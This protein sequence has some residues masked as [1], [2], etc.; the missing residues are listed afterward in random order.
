MAQD[1]VDAA[2]LEE[3]EPGSARGL[4]HRD[5]STRSFADS[6]GLTIG[7]SP[8]ITSKGAQFTTKVPYMSKL[9][10]IASSAVRAADKVKA[11]LIIVYT[12]TGAAGSD[13]AF[14]DMTVTVRLLQAWS[15]LGLVS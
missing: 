15:S 1:A 7:L 10:S 6:E 4:L 12:Q 2:D 11:A 5:T 14:P 9:E 3:M 13:V 8:P